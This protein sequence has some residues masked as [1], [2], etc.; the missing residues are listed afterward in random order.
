MRTESDRISTSV[1]L[2]TSASFPPL[3]RVRSELAPKYHTS[4]VS[5]LVL[6]AKRAFEQ[7]QHGHHWIYSDCA[8][9][10]YTVATVIQAAVLGVEVELNLQ[11]AA[12]RAW[13][14]H[15][16]LAVNTALTLFFIT[17]LL[18]HVRVAG[19][20]YLYMWP[21][22]FDVLLVGISVVDLVARSIPLPPTLDSALMVRSLRAIRLARILRV[23]R[24]VKMVP[25]VKSIC[26]GLWTVM[27]S[28]SWAGLLLAILC[29]MGT[30]MCV[31]LLAT[32][33]VCLP[34]D[35]GGACV[36]DHFSNIGDSF[37]THIMLALGEAW[38]D[39]AAP[40]F[41]V[42]WAWG[43]YAAVFVACTNMLV[44][45]MVTG[46]VCN[47]MCEMAK[48]ERAKET[49]LVEERFASELL[50]L[51]EPCLDDDGHLELSQEVLGKVLRSP[52]VSR[53][54]VSHE[55]PVHVDLEH[56]CTLLGKD[57]NGR[58]N[59][60]ELVGCLQRMR[61][62]SDNI[63]H[64]MQRGMAQCTGSIAKCTSAAHA[65]LRAA[66]KD[67]I[68][69]T[70]LELSSEV[71]MI[72]ESLFTFT[73]EL[74]RPDPQDSAPKAWSLELPDSVTD[75]CSDLDSAL[76]AM[77][78]LSA[79]DLPPAPPPCLPRPAS[80]SVGVQTEDD[81]A[82]DERK[83][84]PEIPTPP[85]D[86]HT[87]SEVLQAS[88]F[89][90]PPEVIEKLNRSKEHHESF[91]AR[92]RTGKINEE[93]Y[94]RLLDNRHLNHATDSQANRRKR[95]LEKLVAPGGGN[96]PAAST[97]R[98][99]NLLQPPPRPPAPPGSGANPEKG[100]SSSLKGK[101]LATGAAL[102]VPLRMPPPPRPPPPVA[103]R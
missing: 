78:H 9:V 21:G 2:R 83:T 1:S 20:R 101:A 95:I 103:N 72:V 61:G 71:D 38:P 84:L 102:R 77:R 88:R 75:A 99:S 47:H 46:V 92:L 3:G 60:E 48:M 80:S 45:N 27:L 13:E 66:M 98:R 23:A 50:K 85:K 24:L 17:D 53:V 19:C 42:H 67:L 37:L 35:S 26:A 30:L 73:P 89:P 14:E 81:C 22:R 63:S 97:P 44:L 28:I 76:A 74:P 6:Q 8:H 93:D 39:I 31:S 51:L 91:F 32:S 65:E 55:V 79:H 62:H 52:A 15:L 25:M 100:P 86:A 68:F 41:A 56:V 40:M 96:S 90:C 36:A 11:A 5:Q 33:T 87:Q 54:L 82:D 18:L 34:E 59:S 94:K 7:G 29:Y 10:L 43:I 70:G 57:Q 58:A 64:A 12:P 49:R 4:V 69:Q 16:F